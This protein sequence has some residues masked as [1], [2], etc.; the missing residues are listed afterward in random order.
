MVEIDIGK[1]KRI[2]LFLSSVNY[3]R[4]IETCSCVSSFLYQIY[5]SF[6]LRRSRMVEDGRFL[7]TAG[8]RNIYGT[9]FCRFHE[10]IKACFL[11]G[12]MTRKL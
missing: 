8:T 2:C 7:R 1:L 6:S 10:I 5:S 9:W 4:I 3:I 11:I 12:N